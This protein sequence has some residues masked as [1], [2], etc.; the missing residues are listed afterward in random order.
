MVDFTV[1][2]Q[3]TL[4]ADGVRRQLLVEVIV[5]KS[6]LLASSCFVLSLMPNLKIDQFQP[7]GVPKEYNTPVLIDLKDTNTFT[8]N[9][10]ISLPPSVVA[11]SQHVR[12][13]AI[14]KNTFSRDVAL[15]LFMCIPYKFHKLVS[16]R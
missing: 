13:T 16:H 4:A 6:N 8:K 3:S 10:L 12:V 7:E 9:I 5:L 1:K 2:A 11:G 14:G 15:V